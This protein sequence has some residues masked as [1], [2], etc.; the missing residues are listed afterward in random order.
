MENK[1]MN[2]DS[3]LE[4]IVLNRE[5]VFK[6]NEEKNRIEATV[7]GYDNCQTGIAF[8]LDNKKE[9]TFRASI[10]ALK[11]SKRRRELECNT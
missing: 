5:V 11:A 2:F 7:L 4:L 10:E 1:I 9:E 3:L 8:K 6:K